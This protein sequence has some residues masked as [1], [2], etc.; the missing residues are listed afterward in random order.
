MLSGAQTQQQRYSGRC[1][2]G[3]PKTLS[4]RRAS[5]SRRCGSSSRHVSAAPPAAAASRD[6]THAPSCSRREQ[7]LSLASAPLL[8]TTAAASAAVA[9]LPAFA[10]DAPDSKEAAA[11]KLL[12]RATQA[13]GDIYQPGPPAPWADRQAYFAR[14]LFGE[15]D[16]E[17][18]YASFS[19]PLGERFVRPALLNAAAAPAADG[20]VGSSYAFR[21][22]YYSTLPDTFSNNARVQL[23][24]MPEDAI[25]ADRAFNARE[26]ANAYLGDPNAGAGAPIKAVQSAQ[27]DPSA[28]PDRLTLEFSRVAPDMQPLPPRRVELYIQNMWV[29]GLAFSDTFW[30]REEGG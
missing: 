13:A 25:I 16:V 28:A 12:S 9:P 14:W 20:G 23:G 11:L 2:G 15:W 10:A 26:A 1:S 7:L 27:Y 8:A 18:T 21:Q 22:R 3:G 19:T 6:A 4:L 17:S 24:F 5:S 29:L 30:G